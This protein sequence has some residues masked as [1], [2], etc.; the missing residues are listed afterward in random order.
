MLSL[1]SFGQAKISSEDLKVVIGN[2]VGSITYLDY[3]T[4]KPFTMPANLNV[5]QGKSDNI[6]LLNNIYPNEPK[7]NSSDKIKIAKN[8]M[9]LN[10]N[11]VTSRE[12]LENE[13]VQIQTEHE[14]K[15]DN[16][17]ALLRYTYVIGNDFFL[18]RKEVQFEEAGDWIKRSE[19]NYQRKK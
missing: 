19:F 17:K 6:L 1:N 9:L 18:I 2:W 4:N 13:H 11:V 15:D 12:E 7:A 14:A 10:K 5:T 3:Q 8:G 16:K